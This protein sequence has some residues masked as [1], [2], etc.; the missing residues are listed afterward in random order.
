MLK[1]QSPKGGRSKEFVI[2]T[3][4]GK[5]WYGL[6]PVTGSF[7]WGVS[8]KNIGLA[9]GL[10]PDQV[11]KAISDAFSPSCLAQ[12]EM[13]GFLGIKK[14]VSMLNVLK[15]IGVYPHIW[16]VGDSEWQRRKFVNS[17]ASQSICRY[18][19]LSLCF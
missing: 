16:T 9:L 7:D 19:S 5:A 14:Q 6:D 18:R 3:I 12:V 1:D 11:D 15:S 2:D 10:R 13:P 8:T 17:G 4:G